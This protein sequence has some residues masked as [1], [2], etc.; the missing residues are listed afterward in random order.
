[1]KQ[2]I[3]RFGP[4]ILSFVLL[5]ACGSNTPPSSSDDAA[6]E[7]DFYTVHPA[8]AG[9]ISGKVI[10]EGEAPP[11]QEIDMNSEPECAKVHSGPILSQRLLVDESGGLANAFLSIEDDFE[12]LKF[13]VP[14]E[15]ITIDQAGCVYTPLVLG[16]RAGQKLMVTNSDPVTHNI[17]PLPRFNRESNRTQ[18]AGAEPLHLPFGRPEMMIPVKCNLHSWM[19]S[20]VSVMSHPFF[21]VSAA[22]GSF[23]IQGLPPGEYTLV[24]MHERLGRQKVA[25]TVGPGESKSI[26][27]LYKQPEG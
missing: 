22:D 2:K 20:F 16:V 25:V 5:C 1:M 18:S 23:E 4:P 21:A 19:V 8:Q 10:Y 9:N 7:E 24:A 6:P 12:D 26:E 13:K 14:S 11:A 3:Q 17:H 27:I 15:P